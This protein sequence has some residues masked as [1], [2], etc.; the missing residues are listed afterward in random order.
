MRK[1]PKTGEGRAT[2]GGKANQTRRWRSQTRNWEKRSND[3]RHGRADGSRSCKKGT[4][5]RNKKQIT[6]PIE[7]SRSST[8]I[9]HCKLFEMSRSLPRRSAYWP[10]AAC[11]TAMDYYLT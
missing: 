8:H 10:A 9:P 1:K 7:N 5:N 3:K 2:R 11:P 6:S 4:R